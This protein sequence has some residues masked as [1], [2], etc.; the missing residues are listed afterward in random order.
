MI[1][2]RMDAAAI[3]AFLAAEFPE[4]GR[5]FTV[6]SAGSGCATIR[7]RTGPEH[8]RPGGTVSG[9]AMFALADVAFYAAVLSAIGPQALAVTTNAAI[10]FMRKPPENSELEAEARLLKL[11]RRLAVG[12]VF[13]R[14]DQLAEPVARASMT[15]AIAPKLS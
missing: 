14:S 4:A 7:L 12:D 10:D 9:P 8:L 11:G 2:T 1:D 6:L 15:Y 5:Q 3:S 13:L